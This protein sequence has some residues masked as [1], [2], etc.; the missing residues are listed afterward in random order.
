MATFGIEPTSA[1]FALWLR[2]QYGIATAAGGPLSNE[3]LEPLPRLLKQRDTLSAE[4]R[5]APQAPYDADDGW[6]DYFDNAWLAYA[7]EHG[8]YPDADALAT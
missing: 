2:D 6:G 5:T 8:A 7:Q 1:Q 3:Q 4:T